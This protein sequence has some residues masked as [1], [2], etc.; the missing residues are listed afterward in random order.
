[1]HTSKPVIRTSL[2]VSHLDNESSNYRFV[3]FSFMCFAMLCGGT[4]PLYASYGT[5]FVELLG[6]SNYQINSIVSMCDY[7]YHISAPFFGYLPFQVQI[8]IGLGSGMFIEL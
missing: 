7:A 8:V 3:V 6:F 4:I 1:M 2:L 5:S